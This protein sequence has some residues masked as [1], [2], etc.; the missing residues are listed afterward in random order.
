MAKAG[1]CDVSQSYVWVNDD[2]T[3]EHG[4]DAS[5]ISNV[6]EAEAPAAPAA[7]G[8]DLNQVADDLG[9]GLSDAGTQLADFGKKA[10]SWGKDQAKGSSSPT[11]PG[12]GF[13]ES[14]GPGD[15]QQ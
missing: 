15:D 2:G 1:W 11:D 9:K 14:S 5:H 13:G 8:T 12:A 4:H 6:Y 7:G 3:D 10:W